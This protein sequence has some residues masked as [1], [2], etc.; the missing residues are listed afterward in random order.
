MSDLDSDKKLVENFL[1]ALGARDIER[2]RSHLSAT[3]RFVFPGGREFGS[4]EEIVAGLKTRYRSVRKRIA[5]VEGYRD[6]AVSV[7]WVSGTLYGEW[8]S[9]D[10]FEGIRFVDRFEVEGGLIRDQRV[11]N[12]SAYA[13]IA[14]G[15]AGHERVAQ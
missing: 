5:N 8:L 4:L 15:A 9:G 14:L 12:D 10:A 2:A 11:W 6:G 13:M 1:V 3:A 7:V